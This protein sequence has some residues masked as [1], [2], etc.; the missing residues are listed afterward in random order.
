MGF[1]TESQ[2]KQQA[3]K[4]QAE[5]NQRLDAILAALEE[6]TALLRQLVEALAVRP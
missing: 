5:T 1:V 2:I 4:G 6:Q 3:K